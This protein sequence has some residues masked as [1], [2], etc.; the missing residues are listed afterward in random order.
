MPVRRNASMQVGQRF[1][2]IEPAAF[3]HEGFDEAQKPVGAVG[4]AA[5]R[6]V[7]IEAL[8]IAALIEP[9]FRAGGRGD[10]FESVGLTAAA[11][12]AIASAS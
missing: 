10:R 9:A 3:R 7:R 12:A 4:E 6:L 11:D 2:V 8:L 5:Q 1:A